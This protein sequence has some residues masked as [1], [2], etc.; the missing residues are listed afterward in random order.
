MTTDPIA[1][2]RDAENY[3]SALHGSVA[4]HDHLAANL[5][6]AGCE[7]R[8][9]IAAALPELAAVSSAV[10]APPTDQAAEVDRLRAKVYEWQGSYLE[11]VKV[12]QEREAEITRLHADRAAVLH[13][14]ADRYERSDRIV[15]QMF[16]HQVAAELRRLADETPDTTPQAAEDPARIDRLRPEFAEHASVEAIDAQLR[17]ARRQMGLWEQRVRKLTGLRQKREGQPAAGA[18]QDGAES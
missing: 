5:A 6:C 4:R 3:L 15:T 14:A 12:R 16:G 1:L 13:W 2:L 9:R 18:W 7:L 11:E 17:R 8:D 10:V